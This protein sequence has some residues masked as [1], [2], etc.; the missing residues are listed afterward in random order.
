MSISFL[1]G[2]GEGS[3]ER[4][5]EVQTFQYLFGT[6]RIETDPTLER[7]THLVFPMHALRGYCARLGSPAVKYGAR[8]SAFGDIVSDHS[9]D[10]RIAYDSIALPNYRLMPTS[11]IRPGPSCLQSR[12]IATRVPLKMT[13]T[14]SS[15]EPNPP[16]LSSRESPLYLIYFGVS[17][18]AALVGYGAHFYLS[19]S[20]DDSGPRT[21]LSGP[22]RKNS[23]SDLQHAISDLC[24][25]FP[26]ADRVLTDAEVLKTYGSPKYVTYLGSEAV[27]PHGV[28]VFPLSTED[29]VVVVDIAKKWGVPIVPFGN[30]SSLEGHIAGVGKLF[31][32]H[33][34][35]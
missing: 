2:L 19:F 21:A 28:V 17:T 32:R 26:G 23:T 15:L 30:G 33:G 35:A 6:L 1:S 4:K 8:G 18:W 7:A 16:P 10:R 5:E 29:V 25:A 31:T 34:L 11:S 12:R 27:H 20:Q 13:K 24:Q 3:G 22:P 9:S 14:S